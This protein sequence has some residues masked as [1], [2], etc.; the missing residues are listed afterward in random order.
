MSWSFS[1]YKKAL[2]KNY[3]ELNPYMASFMGLEEYYKKND[4]ISREKIRENESFLRANIKE[5]ENNR[6]G[7]N[8]ILEQYEAD[9]IHWNLN[10]ELHYLCF[11]KD[12][13]NDPFYY[14]DFLD[15]SV[16]LKLVDKDPDYFAECIIIRLDNYKNV[17]DFMGSNLINASVPALSVY[18]ES[19]SGLMDSIKTDL[20]MV[21]D[22]CKKEEIKNRF[23]DACQRAKSNVQSM[24]DLIEE[25]KINNN[26]PFIIGEERLSKLI[27]YNELKKEDL[28]TLLKKG[29]KEIEILKS[30]LNEI[31]PGISYYDVYSHYLQ[32]CPQEG[33]VIS[34]IEN[35]LRDIS[36]FIKERDIIDIHDLHTLKVRKM[37]PYSEWA[38]AMMDTPGPFIQE[39]LDSYYYITLPKKDWSNEQRQDFLKNFNQYLLENL[40][41]HEALPGHFLHSTYGKRIDSDIIKSSFGY[42]FIEG[43]AH[44]CEEMILE[45]GFR[46]GDPGGEIA[47]IRE[48]MLRLV[49]L[50]SSIRIHT[51]TMSLEESRIQFRELCYLDGET[52][53]QESLRATYDPT[54]LLYTYGKWKIYELRNNVDGKN[55]IKEFHRNMMSLGSPPIGLMEKYYGKIKIF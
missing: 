8:T 26:N 12:F 14:F 39:D 47:R 7:L 49:R 20:K 9:L 34:N 52:A 11:E 38:S 27:Y 45:E 53:K 3:F 29:E 35:I 51:G 23:N 13:Q 17:L 42:G 44:Y 40:S 54:Y 18:K 32:S 15:Y 4:E 16:F 25:L 21:Q 5:I 30:R 22:K 33:E 28:Q 24:I 50:I 6:Y 46:S 1:D 31:K 37:P 36:D 43:W 55:N 10:R 19:L 2:L 48:Q 41:I